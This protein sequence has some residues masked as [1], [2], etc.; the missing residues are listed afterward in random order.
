MSNYNFTS[1]PAATTLVAVHHLALPLFR[2]GERLYPEL[3]MNFIDAPDCATYDLELSETLKGA[4][5]ASIRL[6]HRRLKK[7]DA[8]RVG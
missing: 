7:N 3:D 6:W 4:W 1:L 2:R 5:T 8:D